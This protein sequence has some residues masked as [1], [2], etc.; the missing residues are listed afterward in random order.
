[1]STSVKESLFAYLQ[2]CQKSSERDGAQFPED[3]NIMPDDAIYLMR[4]VN[5]QEVLGVIQQGVD[6][7]VSDPKYPA[8]TTQ[9][10]ETVRMVLNTIIFPNEEQIV[11][12]YPFT[13]PAIRAL[14]RVYKNTVAVAV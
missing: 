11:E 7:V 1:M 13:G 12:V 2:Q 14:G 4:L 10:P 8:H 3:F 6:M 5:I 9:T